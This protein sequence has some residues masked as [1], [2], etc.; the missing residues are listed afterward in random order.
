MIRRATVWSP[1]S[2]VSKIRA[3]LRAKSADVSWGTVSRRLVNDFGLK[4]RKLAKKTRLKPAMKAKRL[5]S[6]Q[7]H[8]NWTFQKWHRV[9][10]SD[11]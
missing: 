7:K 3:V 2:S 6:A 10:F 4:S 11:E 5:A 9:L 1:M 8:E